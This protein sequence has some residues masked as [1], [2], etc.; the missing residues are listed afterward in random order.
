MI[1]KE[2]TIREPD[3]SIWQSILIAFILTIYSTICYY[4]ITTNNDTNIVFLIALGIVVINY[5]VLPNLT[6]KSIHLNFTYKKIKYETSLGRF[7]INQKWKDLK[8][9]K[10]ISVFKT[11]NGYEVNLWHNKNEIINL[12]VYEHYENVVKEA[13]AIAEKLDIELL[14]ARKRGHHQWIDKEVYKKTGKIEYYD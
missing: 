2:F 5:M 13:F 7:S 12:F 3:I 6:T 14:D 11:E 4:F 9:L 8:N 1:E 10:Y